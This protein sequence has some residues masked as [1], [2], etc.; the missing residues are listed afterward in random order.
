L[1]LSAEDVECE[2]DNVGKDEERDGGPPNEDMVPD[3]D[4]AYESLR[5]RIGDGGCKLV[6]GV[7]NRK[8]A[9]EYATKLGAEGLGGSSGEGGGSGEGGRGMSNHVERGV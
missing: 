1:G 9:A 7:S 8:L 6:A 5:S 2:V 3:S 4:V